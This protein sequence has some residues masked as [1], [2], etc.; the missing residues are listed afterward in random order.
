MARRLARSLG[1]SLVTAPIKSS[2]KTATR[3]GKSGETSILVQEPAFSRVGSTWSLG[4]RTP[5]SFAQSA[6]LTPLGGMPLDEGACASIKLGGA[7][8][9]GA[10]ACWFALG[11]KAGSV[12]A[13]DGTGAMR[14]SVTVEF[15]LPCATKTMGPGT[16]G[17]RVLSCTVFLS[18]NPSLG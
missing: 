6:K 12:G 3:G 8:L 14:D 1:N 17:I 7:A 10:R 2:P 16:C 11:D 15:S 13:T 9:A 18:G 4:L 5:C